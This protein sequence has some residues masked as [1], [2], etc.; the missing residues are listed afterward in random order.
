M[1]E[2][3][4]KEAE[5]I[6]I[7]YHSKQRWE[8]EPCNEYLVEFISE[9]L[10]LREDK[11]TQKDNM[12]E[13]LKG[14]LLQRTK[15]LFYRQDICEGQVAKIKSQEAVIKEL[16]KELNNSGDGRGEWHV[17]HSCV[18]KEQYW[19]LEKRIKE[20]E[21]MNEDFLRARRLDSYICPLCADA[22]NDGYYN[23]AKRA[24]SLLSRCEEVLLPLA[25]ASGW[26]LEDGKTLGETICFKAKEL[27]SELKTSRGD[28]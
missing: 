6:A 2:E 16:Q 22:M 21:A 26:I 15:D 14:D 9:A 24:L 13:S 23:S 10:Q 11:I 28:K 18:P 5:E 19:T 8:S 20:L 3:I 25:T 4:R 1:N 17:N 7:R 27:L 12:L